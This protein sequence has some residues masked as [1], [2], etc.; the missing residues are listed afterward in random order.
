MSVGLSHRPISTGIIND[1]L[2]L[3]DSS[4]SVSHYVIVFAL[5]MLTALAM[6]TVGAVS[7]GR[8]CDVH[9]QND[10]VNQFIL[11]VKI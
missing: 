1:R 4:E 5:T 9:A 8:I 11:L 7:Y 3:K 6:P 2:N 10:L